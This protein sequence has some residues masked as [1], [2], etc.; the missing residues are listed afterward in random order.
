M[1]I[2]VIIASTVG[3]FVITLLL[4]T[5]LLVAKDKLLPSGPVKLVIN[6]EKDVEVS[7]G[8]TLLTT[9]GNNKIFLPSACG[10]GGTCVQCKCQVLEGGGEI[11]PTEEPHFTRKEISEGWRLGCQV[12]VKQDM[13]IEVPEEVF[14]IKKWE[15]KV[16]SNY[17]VA[18]FIKEFVIEIPEEMDY[19]AGGYIQIEIPECDINYQDIDITSHPQEHP[20]DPQKFKHE[21]DNFNLWPLNM[22]NDETVERAYSMASYPAEG[23]EIMLNVRIATPPWDAKKND[24]MSVNPGIASS[25]IFS[26][27]PGDTVTISGPYGEFFIN[28]SDAEML[29]VGGGAGMAP[30]RSHLYELFRTIKTGRKVTFW[31]GG[32]SKRELFYVDHFRALEKDFP[33]FKFYIA[34]SEPLEEDNWKV[35]DSLEGDGD[36][37]VGFIHQVVI[38]NYLSNHDSPED[39]EVYFCGPPLMNQAVDKMAEDFGVPPE[40]VRFDDFGG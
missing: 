35:K 33:N 36:G 27:K 29:Y 34:L 9:L 12:K 3:L 1:D 21:W 8:D 31:Y 25:Y 14:G 28:D 10:G 19:K 22:K 6:G 20:D 39:I 40:N 4:V 30:M 37:F 32:R 13:K 23:K 38:D 11:L 5:M 18:S 24:W 2:N 26:K 16:K 7:S 15:A 17:N